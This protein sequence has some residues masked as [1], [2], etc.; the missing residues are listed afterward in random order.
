MLVSMLYILIY[1]IVIV[2]TCTRKKSHK[3]S[4]HAIQWP[5]YGTFLGTQ[6]LGVCCGLLT[7]L[8]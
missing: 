3:V 6:Y 7:H 4:W 2:E 1:R 5:S 8:I